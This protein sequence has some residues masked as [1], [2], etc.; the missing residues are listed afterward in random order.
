MA[1]LKSGKF[2]KVINKFNVKTAVEEIM[3][4]QKFSSD[5]RNI[6]M[7]VDFLLFPSRELLGSDSRNQGSNQSLPVNVS[8]AE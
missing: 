2:R 3:H 4:I 5:L 7:N 1:Q 8:P 6:K